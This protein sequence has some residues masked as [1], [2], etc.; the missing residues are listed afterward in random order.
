MKILLCIIYLMHL[1]VTAA[2]ARGTEESP[3]SV[4]PSK[5]N[6]KPHDPASR[7]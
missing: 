6:I 7:L 2:A 3:N 1:D 5:V 4:L